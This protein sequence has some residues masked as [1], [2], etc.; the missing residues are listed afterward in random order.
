MEARAGADPHRRGGR[1]C[2]GLGLAGAPEGEGWDTT[3][4]LG[5][6]T[7]RHSF[8]RFR[9]SAEHLTSGIERT[10]TNSAFYPFRGDVTQFRAS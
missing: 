6:G 4:N 5:K 7:E 3:G 9:S 8:I 1:S 10:K 2:H